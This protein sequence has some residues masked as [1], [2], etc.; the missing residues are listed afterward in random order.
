MEYST[1]LP[2]QI[3]NTALQ[4]S[5]AFFYSPPSQVTFVPY[6]YPPPTPTYTFYL[7]D[8]YEQPKALP[9]PPTTAPDDSPSS[10]LYRPDSSLT[11]KKTTKRRCDSSAAVKYAKKNA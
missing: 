3:T 6:H 7:S 1:F 5:I 10:E 4:P 11:A 9:M 2:L 8:S